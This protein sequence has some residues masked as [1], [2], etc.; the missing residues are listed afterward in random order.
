MSPTYQAAEPVW[1][2][3][4]QL[5]AGQVGFLVMAELKSLRTLTRR[6]NGGKALRS[7]NSELEFCRCHSLA[8]TRVALLRAFNLPG[9][10][11]PTSS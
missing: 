5:G 2:S 1:H 4:I 11:S 10:Q 3:G 8:P 6:R 7:I 9:S